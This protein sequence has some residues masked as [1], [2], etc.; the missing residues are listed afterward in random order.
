[1]QGNLFTHQAMN[2]MAAHGIF[3]AAEPIAAPNPNPFHE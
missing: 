3:D 1:M 2:P